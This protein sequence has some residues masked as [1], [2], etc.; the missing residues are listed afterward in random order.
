M[1]VT[2]NYKPNVVGERM[3]HPKKKDGNYDSV[4]GDRIISR[5]LQMCKGVMIKG[6]DRRF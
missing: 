3:N 5:L 4:T 6:E 1:V 2:S